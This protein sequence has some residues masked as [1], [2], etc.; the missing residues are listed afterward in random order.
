MRR[1]RHSGGLTQE[2]ASAAIGVTFKYYQRMEA[3]SI[4]GVRLSTISQ[5]AAA[6]GLSLEQLFGTTMPPGRPV[7]KVWAPPHRKAPAKAKGKTIPPSRGKR[8]RIEGEDVV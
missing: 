3:G 6:Y 5:V 2:Q 7:R 1:L 4:E 8:R